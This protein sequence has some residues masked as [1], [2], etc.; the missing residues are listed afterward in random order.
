MLS[1]PRNVA[2]RSSF[3]CH[4]ER[5]Q[6]TRPAS[7]LAQSKDPVFA[8]SVRE[9]IEEFLP[10]MR[11]LKSVQRTPRVAAAGY[12]QTRGP[13]TPHNRPWDGHA[14]LGMTTVEAVPS[15]ACGSFA[16]HRRSS[17]PGHARYHCHL[18]RS[19]RRGT[20]QV[21]PIWHPRAPI[22]PPPCHCQ[23][24]PAVAI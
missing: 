7:P 17:S 3:Y 9:L 18:E 12:T 22:S 13:S 6:R 19:Q 1:P 11:G 15:A 5:S 24:A 23:S 21:I 14:P 20:M 8:C 2:S 10:Q 4:L 16:L